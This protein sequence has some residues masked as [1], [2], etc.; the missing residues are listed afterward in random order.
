MGNNQDE[1]TKSIPNDKENSIQGH[2]TKTYGNA[3][4]E[5]WNWN[6]FYYAKHGTIPCEYSSGDD[7]KQKPDMDVEKAFRAVRQRSPEDPNVEQK[8]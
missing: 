7:G 4:I 1:W 6:E 8:S 3:I 5:Y 2:M